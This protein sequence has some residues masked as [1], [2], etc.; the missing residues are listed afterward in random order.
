[1]SKHQ[2]SAIVLAAGKGSR[3]GSDIPKQYLTVCDYPILYYS[4]KAFED[5]R[6]S[7]V[8]LVTGAEDV[9][10]CQKNIV[11]KYGFKKVL[12]IVSGGAKRYDSVYSG[13]CA[14]EETEYVL[15]Q[16]GA[17]PMLDAAIIGRT[18]AALENIKACV[19][20]MPVKDTIKIAD[21][22]GYA[23]Q[24]PD[25]NLLWQIQ[26]PQAF[27]Y[28]LIR[29]SYEKMF[30]LKKQDVQNCPNITDDAMVVEHFSGEKVKLIEG[31]YENIKVTTPEDLK[32]AEI[33]LKK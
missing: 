24:T 13:I 16:D 3:M 20:G 28:Q 30:Q 27:S 12:R 32:L 1:M 14:L 6:V 4:L 8:V 9:E 5:S 11:E 29:T 15:I 25:R 18:I 7:Q 26:T 23:S 31:S 33:F 17:R 2:Y 10:Y 21:A 22:D 19:V